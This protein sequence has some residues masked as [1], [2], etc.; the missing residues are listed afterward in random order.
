MGDSTVLAIRH[1]QQD[2]DASRS[3]AVLDVKTSEPLVTASMGAGHSTNIVP[4]AGPLALSPT[5]PSADT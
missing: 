1:V 4:V 5:R 3:P 2:H